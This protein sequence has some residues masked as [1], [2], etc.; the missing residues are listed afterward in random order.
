MVVSLAFGSVY[1]WKLFLMDRLRHCGQQDDVESSCHGVEEICGASHIP[2]LLLSLSLCAFS[3]CRN[4][5][6]HS[7]MAASSSTTGSPTARCITTSVAARCALG[8]RS[9]SQDAASLL[10]A[11]NFTPNTLSVPSASSSSTKEPSKNRTTSP[12]VRTAF[13]NS[14]VRG[15]LAG[16]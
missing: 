7:S 13:S 1:P 14:S 12:T 5:S 2:G 11:R 16:S 9:P 10:W 15:V 3:P 8:A 4:V 6:P